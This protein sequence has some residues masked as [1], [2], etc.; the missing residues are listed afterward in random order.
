MMTPTCG[1]K[2][3]FSKSDADV[4]LIPKFAT[5]GHELFDPW[6]C[7]SE[8]LWGVQFRDGMS[9]KVFNILLNPIAFMSLSQTSY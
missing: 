1:L 2:M 8:A 6:C 5:Q 7:H 4:I 3:V 9:F